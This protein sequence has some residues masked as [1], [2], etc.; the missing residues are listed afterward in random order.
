M[1][2]VVAAVR[3]ILW[4]VAFYSG[5]LVLLVLAAAVYPVSFRGF[6]ALVRLWSGWQRGTAYWV[7]DQRVRIDGVIPRGMAFFVFKHEAMFE[8]IDLPWLLDRPMVFAKD[9]LGRL[10]IWGM[11]ASRYGLI[12]IARDAGAKTLRRMRKAGQ[13]AVAA[14]RPLV[15][16]P[17]GTRVAHGE[18][19]PIKSGFAGIY[20]MLDMAVVPVAV[21]TGRLRHGWIRLPGVITYRVGETVPAGLDRDEAEARVH[22]A[23]NALN[24]PPV[25]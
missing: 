5:T 6:Q 14:N 22:A 2:L 3:T 20:K 11:L 4:A 18:A 10:P 19:P 16:L 8:T 13:D 25:A 21:D 1:R 23:I 17:E 15:L 24:T 12:F 7:L 9:E